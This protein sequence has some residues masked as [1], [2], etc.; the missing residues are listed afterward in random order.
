M[1]THSIPDKRLNMKYVAG[2]ALILLVVSASAQELTDQQ[3][4]AYATASIPDKDNL[5]E[6]LT[7]QTV[8]QLVIQKIRQTALENPE[9]ANQIRNLGQQTS[10]TETTTTILNLPREE[11][12]TS[13]TTKQ[14]SPSTVPIIVATT[15]PPSTIRRPP[16]TTTIQPPQTTT[17]IRTNSTTTTKPSAYKAGD[18]L[19][20]DKSLL[21]RINM[22]V[23][24]VLLLF[25]IILIISV[26][27]W[28]K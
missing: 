19:K 14:T 21:D 18:I 12:T 26:I 3:I 1:R 28:S 17:T 10:T 5:Q 23:L 8:Q 16:E 13:T 6:F 25:I 11:P 9:L 7:N 15:N 27:Y 20:N 22:P 24:I 4:I 2:L